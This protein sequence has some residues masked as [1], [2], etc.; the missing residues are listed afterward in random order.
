MGVREV[1]ARPEDHEMARNFKRAVIKRGLRRSGLCVG[2][3]SALDDDNVSTDTQLNRRP[4]QTRSKK[5]AQALAAW[6]ARTGFSPNGVSMLGLGFAAAGAGAMLA[7][8]WWAGA[9]CV[10]LRLLC[11]MLDGLIAVEHGKGDKLGGFF[12]EVPDRAEDVLLLVAAG[13][14]GS[15]ATGADGLSVVAPTLGWAA[16]VLALGTAYL[17]QAGGAMGLAQDFCGPMAKQHRMFVLTVTLIAAGFAPRAG[18]VVEIGLAV[19]VVGAA[20]TVIRRIVRLAE[21]LKAR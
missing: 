15:V 9:V 6:M 1:V 16:A 17:R 5:W 2:R 11:N 14:G 7:G 13:Y 3:W 10:Q 18:D 12:N 4:L 21:A 19:I 8:W 20:A